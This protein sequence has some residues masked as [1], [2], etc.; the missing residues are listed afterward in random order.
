MAAMP[1]SLAVVVSGN[2]TVVRIV[3]VIGV[4]VDSVMVLVR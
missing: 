4:A 2:V 1:K 3:F